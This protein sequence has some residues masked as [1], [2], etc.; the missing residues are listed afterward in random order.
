MENHTNPGPVLNKLMAQD[1]DWT[2]AI[3]FIRGR[4]PIAV[5]ADT[6]LKAYGDTAIVMQ[7]V[8]GHPAPQSQADA[9]KEFNMFNYIELSEIYGV[10]FYSEKLIA[11][12]NGGLVIGRG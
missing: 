6:D 12:P 1:R 4:T 3:I 5:E 2:F 7:S 10:D 11:G 8:V 9:Q